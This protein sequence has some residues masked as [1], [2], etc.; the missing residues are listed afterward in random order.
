MENKDESVDSAIT[1]DEGTK[2]KSHFLPKRKRNSDSIDSGSLS[3]TESQPSLL[4]LTEFDEDGTYTLYFVLS[5]LW[6]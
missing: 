4:N 5:G 2:R 6:P 3:D 1:E